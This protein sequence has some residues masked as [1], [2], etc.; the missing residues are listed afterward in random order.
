VELSPLRPDQVDDGALY[1]RL[2][3]DAHRMARHTR[4]IV[5]A[6]IGLLL[7]FG[8]VAIVRSGGSTDTPPAAPE[9]RTIAGAVDLNASVGRA[10]AAAGSPCTGTS[11]YND[12]REG[13][14]VLVVDEANKTIATASLSAGSFQ[15]QRGALCT[16]TFSVPNVPRASFYQVKVNQRGG[17]TYSFAEMETRGWRVDL[18]LG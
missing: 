7:I 12:V 10:T 5:L 6:T 17:P 1:D 11:G 9:S 16:F 14:Q 2:D 8:L 3:A 13:A 15:P 18:T 4:W